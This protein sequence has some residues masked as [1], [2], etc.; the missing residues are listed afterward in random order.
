MNDQ[1]DSQSGNSIWAD[2]NTARLLR[3]RGKT[4]Y[5]S[6]YFHHIILP[7]L[8]IPQA[9]NL[10]DVGC[11][12][13]G[14]A[15]LL[16][17]AKPDLNITAVDMETSALKSAA[18]TADHEGICNV[19]FEQDDAHQLKFNDNRFDTVVCQTLLTHVRDAGKVVSEMAR[20]LV[21][22]GVFMAAE[23]ITMGD[24]S[25]YDNVGDS[26]R[27]EFWRQEFYRIRNLYNQGKLV[28][29]RGD[30]GLGIRVPLLMTAAGLD[31]FD[32][33]LNDR[34]LHVIP[35]YRHP[36]QQDYL[37]LLGTTY[38]E[39]SDPK[40]FE[41]MK[42]HIRAAGG[43]ER[44]AE[45]LYTAVDNAAMREAIEEKELTM[46]SSYRLYLTFARKPVY[47]NLNTAR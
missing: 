39:D 2:K 47:V 31:V 20:V 46:I 10:L 44:D 42:E 38:A 41:R 22:G 36:K 29:E 3:L 45:W 34:V 8:D 18:Q 11:G 19:K 30:D 7:L 21:P 33:R 1:T 27:D 17:Q 26:K 43:M 6:D 4:F 13:G 14:L 32:V 9:G 40:R 35:P 5:N 24:W 23:Y 16:A 37:E 28:M 15:L 25:D 12:Y